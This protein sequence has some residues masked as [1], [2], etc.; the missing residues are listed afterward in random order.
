MK[1]NIKHLTHS[2][3][4]V[5]DNNTKLIF[6]PISPLKLNTQDKNIYIFVSHSHSDHFSPK[7][8]KDLFE[9]ENV[10]FIFS[11]DI[12]TEVKNFKIKN[13]F[14]LDHYENITINDLDISTYGTTDLGNSYLV[15]L[16]GKNIF[17]S[18]D[19]NWWHWKRMTSEELK[20]EETDF[21]REVGLLEGKSID[22]AFIPV[23]PR[24][25]K[26]GY[27]AINYFIDLINPKYVIPMHSFGQFDY[28]GDLESHIHLKKSKLINV[29]H[30][31]EIIL[32][33]NL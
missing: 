5:T 17:H 23:D 24:L 31:N 13:L 30:E 16:N 25:E 3:F 18:G 4:I 12:S 1:M 27:L 9:K 33:K 29:N 21:K 22:F 11:K 6:D 7:C 8:L 20:V 28:Y 26:H 32:D 14:L 15:N 10:Y 19:L 2:G